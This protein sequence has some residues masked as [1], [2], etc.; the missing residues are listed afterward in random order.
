MTNP[1]RA[2]LDAALTRRDN[3]ECRAAYLFRERG[4]SA[5][6]QAAV[7]DFSTAAEAVRRARLAMIQSR[8]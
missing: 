5:E 2:R 8:D 3:A 6:Y 1:A 7:D 4:K